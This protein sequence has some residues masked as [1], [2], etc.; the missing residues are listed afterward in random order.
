MLF[1]WKEK[2]LKELAKPEN[3]EL[4][5]VKELPPK[6]CGRSLFFGNKLDAQVQLYVKEL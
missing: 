2:Y 6:K 1:S 5:K 3:N 4:P